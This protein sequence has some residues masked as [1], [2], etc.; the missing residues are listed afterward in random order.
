MIGHAGWLLFETKL[1]FRLTAHSGQDAMKMSFVA[2]ETKLNAF[3]HLVQDAYRSLIR[4]TAGAVFLLPP[5]SIYEILES[6]V[7]TKRWIRYD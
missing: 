6:D 1:F 5:T 4:L 2:A 3:S 7:L